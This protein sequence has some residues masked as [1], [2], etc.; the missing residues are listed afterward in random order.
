MAVALIVSGYLAI[1][2][3][4]VEINPCTG[5]TPLLSSYDRFVYTK[6]PFCDHVHLTNNKR[7]IHSKIF[8]IYFILESL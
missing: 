8:F 3:E 6:M 4:K 2:K 7:T 1:P 5:I